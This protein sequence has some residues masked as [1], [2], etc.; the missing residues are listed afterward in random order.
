[1]LMEHSIHP[2]LLRRRL[3]VLVV[4]CGGTGSAIVGGLPY[5]HLALVANGHPAGLQVTV[6]DGDTIS[7]SKLGTPAFRF[8]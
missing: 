1:M 2:E 4:G 8:G 5:L 7:P 3:R 6:I